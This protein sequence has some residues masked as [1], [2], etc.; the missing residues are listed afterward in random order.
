MMIGIPPDAM[1]T[2]W[3]YEGLSFGYQHENST[4]I[5]LQAMPHCQNIEES[6]KKSLIVW[7]GDGLTIDLH[8][9]WQSAMKGKRNSDRPSPQLIAS[10]GHVQVIFS[11]SNYQESKKTYK[12]HTIMWI[13]YD[14]INM[15]WRYGNRMS[16][17]RSSSN[18]QCSF[19]MTGYK[20]HLFLHQFLLYILIF[21]KFHLCCHSFTCMRR[22]VFKDSDWFV[23]L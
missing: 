23:A 18:Y 9:L 1:D 2:A 3:S 19:I 22:I 10:C 11:P 20:I 12:P 15:T 4:T 21:I 16:M 14:D 17:W 8:T 6:V 7:K 5:K 13:W